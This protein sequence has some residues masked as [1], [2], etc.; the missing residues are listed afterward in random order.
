M[1]SDVLLAGSIGAL[2]VFL[3]GIFREWWREE[4]EREALLRLLAAEIEHNAEVFRIIGEATW[5]LLSSPDFRLLTTKTWHDLQG[6]AGALLPSGL[7]VV[8]NGYY[9]SLQTLQTLQAFEH[10]S[11]ERMAR[12]LRRAYSELTGE[13]VPASTNPWD[14]YLKATMEAQDNALYL[15]REYQALRSH[16]RLLIRLVRGFESLSRPRR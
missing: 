12:E 3:L 10:R 16:E 13:Q 6:R 11:E 4:R 7:T 5:D 14:E 2:V 9:S 15:I 1:S 8:L